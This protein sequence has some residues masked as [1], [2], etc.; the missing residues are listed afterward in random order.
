M[1]LTRVFAF[2]GAFY[3]IRF[4]LST[5]N[6]EPVVTWLSALQYLILTEV[7]Q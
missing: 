1:S 5:H 2:I 3:V 7:P 4:I 6:L